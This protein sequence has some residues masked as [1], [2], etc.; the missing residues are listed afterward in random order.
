MKKEP[1]A[2]YIFEKEIFDL[3]AESN[4]FNVRTEQLRGRGAS[5]QIDAFGTLAIPTAFTY[6]I[7]L[8]AEAKCYSSTIQLHQI[9]SFVGVIK[10]ISENY[11]VGENDQRNTPNRYLDTGC[12][13]SATPF[14]KSSQDYA[15]A[16]NIFLV[17]FSDM[18]EML[19]II[20]RIRSFIFEIPEEQLRTITKDDLL[21]RYISWKN[22]ISSENINPSLGIGILDNVYPVILVGKKDW[23]ERIRV[24]RNSDT[25]FAEKT[26]REDKINGTI[27]HL[28]IDKK[29]GHPEIVS[30]N[31][32]NR[33]AEKII[34]RIDKTAAGEKIF[35]LDIPLII[36][37]N[38]K[39][40][41]RILRVVVNLPGKEDYIRTIT[42]AGFNRGRFNRM[43]FNR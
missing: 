8:I 3:L 23:H 14:S 42:S 2:G 10:D 20:T 12:F 15:W 21:M 38:G 13:F 34:E 24:P 7:R 19:S 18:E 36:K 43:G 41:R 28:N 16:H 17:S 6:P 29:N 33:I 30:F 32:P 39:T 40:V 27:F 5:H 37:N 31:L 4:Y 1:A 9:R 22:Q 35:D 26:R 25:I 11:I